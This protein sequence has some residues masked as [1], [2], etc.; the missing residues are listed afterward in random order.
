M[1]VDY[2]QLNFHIKHKPLKHDNKE[3]TSAKSTGT[4]T[5][6]MFHLMRPMEQTKNP[7]DMHPSY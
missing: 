3:H 4:L 2:T 6:V 1:L 5:F 7:Q